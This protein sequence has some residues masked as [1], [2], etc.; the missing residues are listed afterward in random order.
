MRHE[1][2]D[3]YGYVR[4]QLAYYKIRTTPVFDPP[5]NSKAKAVIEA[6]WPILALMEG[7]RQPIEKRLEELDVYLTKQIPDWE[8]FLEQ[9]AE[10]KVEEELSQEEKEFLADQY[11]PGTFKWFDNSPI[12]ASLWAKGMLSGYDS[13]GLQGLIS[14]SK[15]GERV[16][17]RCWIELNR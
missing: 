15:K 7:D 3:L 5:I 13:P 12:V 8:E 6:L 4:M 1:Y 17:E 9:L 14:L 11:R 10:E 16:G 2:P